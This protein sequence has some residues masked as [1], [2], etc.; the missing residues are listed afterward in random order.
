MRKNVLVSFEE[1]EKEIVASG[2]K[3]GMCI[4]YS[5]SLSI[6]WNMKQLIANQYINQL[7]SYSKLNISLS[8]F[9]ILFQASLNLWLRTLFISWYGRIIIKINLGRYFCQH[10][11]ETLFTASLFN[12][13]DKLK[14]GIFFIKR[15]CNY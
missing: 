12:G 15:R 6:L 13:I 3:K 11:K 2:V 5:I 10:L 1:V 8:A 7:Y 9:L 14:I 4:L